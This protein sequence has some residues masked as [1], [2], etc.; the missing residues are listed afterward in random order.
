MTGNIEGRNRHN[1]RNNTSTMD[2]HKLLYDKEWN[3]F[4]LSNDICGAM[5]GRSDLR[6]NTVGTP[7]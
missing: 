5:R 4:A 7:T 6:A 1:A 2:L 3:H